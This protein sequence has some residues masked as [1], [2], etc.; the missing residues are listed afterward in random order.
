MEERFAHLRQQRERKS[1]TRARTGFV[2]HYPGPT[3]QAVIAGVPQLGFSSSFWLPDINL[4]NA[5]IGGA[6][7]FQILSARTCDIIPFVS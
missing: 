4:K 7:F 1:V 2:T 6:F 3:T 5:P